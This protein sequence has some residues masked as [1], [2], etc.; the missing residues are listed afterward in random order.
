ML[1]ARWYQNKKLKR[2]QREVNK[3]SR[4]PFIPLLSATGLLIY[5]VVTAPAFADS[6]VDS[7]SQSGFASN[8]Q[9]EAATLDDILKE[10]F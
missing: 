7:T 3:M 9:V 6:D 8:T 1:E 4:S 5:L 2:T 10:F